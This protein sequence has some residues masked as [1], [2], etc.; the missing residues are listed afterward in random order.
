MQDK[1]IIMF[2]Y[3]EWENYILYSEFTLQDTPAEGHQV[4]A[5][6]AGGAGD[7]EA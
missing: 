7:S 3:K 5:A 4:G 2:I 6:G 1:T